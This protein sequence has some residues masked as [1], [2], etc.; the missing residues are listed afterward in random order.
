M[1]P[2]SPLLPV[3]LSLLLLLLLLLARPLQDFP[4]LLLL[5]LA[6]PLLLALLS[7]RPAAKDSFSKRSIA[8]SKR[9]TV[10]GGSLFDRRWSLM[11]P[12]H[13]TS[14]TAEKQCHRNLMHQCGGSK[15]LLYLKQ[16]ALTT[17]SMKWSML[18]INYTNYKTKCQDAY[19]MWT[20]PTIHS[21][22]KLHNSQH[23]KE[24]NGMTTCMWPSISLVALCPVCSGYQ[25]YPAWDPPTVKYMLYTKLMYL[26]LNI[27]NIWRPEIFTFWAEN[28]TLI[29]LAM[30]NSPSN[31]CFSIHFCF[32]GQHSYSKVRQTHRKR[33][34]TH[35]VAHLNNE[36]P[37]NI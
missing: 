18:M 37:C 17:L 27:F 23:Q 34:E 15:N 3:V 13:A 1:V 12:S 14:C 5:P 8:S 33:N 11:S 21:V 36:H 35:S 25:S 29:T 28:G 31:F 10:N 7:S 30:G 6:R 22:N 24:T 20:T 32:Q 9:S 19:Q 2:P 26:F 16:L 4:M